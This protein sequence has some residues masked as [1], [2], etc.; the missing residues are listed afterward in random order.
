MKKSWKGITALMVSV[1]LIAGALFGLHMLLIDGLEGLI[2]ALLL[3]EDTEYATGYTDAGWRSVQIGMT[4][5]DVHAALGDPLQSRTNKDASV[6][7][8]WTRSSGYTNYRNRVLV[9]RNGKVSKK[10]AEFYLD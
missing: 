9:F 5:A 3:E 2:F 8:G 10:H 1:T 7:M 6:S 4:W